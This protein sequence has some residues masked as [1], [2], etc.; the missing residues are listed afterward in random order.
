MRGFNNNPRC[1]QF[2]SAYKK[3]CLHVNCI[4]PQEANCSLQDATDLL[5]VSST[6][7]KGDDTLWE[8][9]ISLDHDYEASNGWSW[10]QYCSEVVTHIAGA[11]VKT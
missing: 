5:Q 1:R 3:L 6:Q 10:N 2:R 9:A 7:D 11:I 4:Y 8:D